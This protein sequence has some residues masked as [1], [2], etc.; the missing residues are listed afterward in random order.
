MRRFLQKRASI[1]PTL[2]TVKPYLD[3]DVARFLSFAIPRP[4]RGP[5]CT[6]LEA[7]HSASLNHKQGFSDGAERW[8]A[9]SVHPMEGFLKR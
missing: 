6:I 3:C 4:Q 8:H 5:F 9:D 7:I 2:F 1:T